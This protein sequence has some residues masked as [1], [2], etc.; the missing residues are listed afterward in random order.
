[1]GLADLWLIMNLSAQFAHAKRDMRDL[2]HRLVE[3]WLLCLFALP[4][5]SLNMHVLG[6][7]AACPRHVL[8]VSHVKTGRGQQATSAWEPET[9][10]VPTPACGPTLSCDAPQPQVRRRR[11][12]H[13]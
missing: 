1:M 12:P 2:K 7:A 5:G 13:Q 8:T 11:S 6:S 4:A 9:V 3:L 10:H